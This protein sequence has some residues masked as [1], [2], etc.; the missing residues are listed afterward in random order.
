ML[1]H[2]LEG[3]VMDKRPR[4]LD[5]SKYDKRAWSDLH[6]IDDFGPSLTVQSQKEEAD[7]NN[8]VAAFGVTGQLPQGVR[9]PTYGDFDAVDDYRT[10]IEMVREAEANFLKL[11]SDL[12]ARLD[13]DPARFV[14][15]ASDPSNLEEMRKLGLAP[16]AA[17]NPV[18]GASA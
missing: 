4:F 13:H 9:V 12:R 16:P 14:D 5:A 17:D 15:F 8:I 2:I 18:P 10:A 1:V 6:A 7:I 11:P 3:L